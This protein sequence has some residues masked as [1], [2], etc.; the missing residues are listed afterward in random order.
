[1]GR[2]C[3]FD[4]CPWSP[5]SQPPISILDARCCAGTWETLTI[6]A[7]GQGMARAGGPVVLCG[8]A[9]REMGPSLFRLQSDA[10]RGC[11]AWRLRAVALGSGSLGLDSVI[12]FVKLGCSEVKWDFALSAIHDT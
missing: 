9:E 5:R 7:V 4:F 3:E 10:E 6:S 1:M 2:S 8:G 11:I 12:S